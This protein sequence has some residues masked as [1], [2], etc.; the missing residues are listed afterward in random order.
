VKG[1]PLVHTPGA[2][3]EDLDRAEAALHGFAEPEDE[4]LRLTLE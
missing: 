2:R 1:V 3:I 4:L